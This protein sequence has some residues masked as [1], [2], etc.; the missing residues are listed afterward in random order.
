MDRGKPAPGFYVG[1]LLT[2]TLG[3]CVVAGGTWLVFCGDEP[4]NGIR[5]E[6]LEADLNERLPDG[7]T[8]AQA[9][10]WFASHGIEATVGT[11]PEG[12]KISLHAQIRNDS[13]LESAEIR[14]DLDFSSDGRIRERSIYR[15][16]YAL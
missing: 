16:V 1:L 5:V 3:L 11:D 15:F 9:E 12:R 6:Q 7:S 8:W 14:I 2:V 13:F 4:K 10:A